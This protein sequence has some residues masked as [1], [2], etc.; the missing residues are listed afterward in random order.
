MFTE[1]TPEQAGISSR[2]VSRFLQKLEQRGLYT[3][4]VLLARGSRIFCEG[5]WAPY[6]ADSLNRLYSQTKSFE[7]IAIC[8]L[9]DEGKLGL[10]DRIVD[11]FP[12]KIHCEIPA[13]LAHQTIRHMLTMQTSR[14]DDITWFV[15]KSAVDRTEFYLNN[16]SFDRE[17][18]LIWSYDSSG[19]QVLASLVEKLTGMRLLDY[20][21][22][23]LFNAMGTFTTA[24]ILKTRNGDSWGDS[25]MLCTLRDV[26]SFGWLLMNGGKYGDTQLIPEAIVKEA[27]A[28]HVDNDHTGFTQGFYG[29]GY[30]YQIWRYMD[31]F[32]FVGMGGQLTVA[33]PER[34]L[35]FSVTGDNQGLPSA[36]P[37]ILACLQDF[38]LDALQNAPL[39][40]DPEAYAQLQARLSSLHLKH[41]P[42]HTESPYQKQ[43][44]G[45]RYVCEEN[46]MGITEFSFRFDSPDTGVFCYRNEQGYKELP[47]GLGKNVFGKFPQWGYSDEYGGLSGGEDFFYNCAASAAWREAQKLVLKVQIIDKYL[48]NFFA[49]F[50][51]R[52][53][54]ACVYIS[55]TAEDFLSE[56]YGWINAKAE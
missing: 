35:L 32:A 18:G 2:S 19:S 25:A 47:F 56:Y 31:G 1:I 51:F 5:Y 12:E 33:F 28:A 24:R 30:G 49:I 22:E 52:D 27:T 38:I 9:A 40:E 23:K 8:L 10:D 17:P 48:G 6:T 37:M 53:D 50:S 11:H 44:Q 46:R 41:I 21:K 16:G 3:H 36:Y 13:H 20:L 54:T 4:S 42:G 34:D 14:P 43:L 15:D 29:H 45:V 39:P 7:G 26:A 55:K